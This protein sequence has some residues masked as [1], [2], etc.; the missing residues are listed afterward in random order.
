MRDAKSRRKQL[1]FYNDKVTAKIWLLISFQQKLV[2]PTLCVAIGIGV[3][4]YFMIWSTPVV[5]G[6]GF[7]YVLAGPVTHYCVYD[8]K[9][10]VEYYFYFNKGLSKGQLYTFTLILNLAL[11]AIILQYG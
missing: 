11:G 6:I 3:A 10:P 1:H 4:G 7:G 8:L 5:Q 9:S 2:L